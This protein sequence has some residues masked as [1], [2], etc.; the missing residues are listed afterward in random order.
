MKIL[1]LLN[2]PYP[3]G[4]ALTKRF[5]LYAKGFRE[6]GHISKFIIP[7]P[8][9]KFG[10]SNNNSSKGSFEGVPFEYA[11]KKCERSN[12]FF[13]R[14][15]HDIYGSIRTGFMIIKEN[16]DIVITDS[17]SLLFYLYIKTIS[18]LIPYKFVQEKCEV[19][20][21]K[22]DKLSLFAKIHVKIMSRFF[23][24]FIVINTQLEE[25]IIHDLKIKTPL[26][27]IPILVEDFK[28]LNS[29]QIDKTIVY[30]GTFL[31]RKDG[32]LTIISAFSKFRIAH[33][34]YKLLLT[35]IPDNSPDYQKINELI[36]Q[37]N[38][39]NQVMFTGYLKEKELRKIIQNATLLI[40]AKPENRQNH[41]NFPTKIGEYMITG[42]PILATRVGVIG[43]LLTDN[44]NIFFAN[45]EADA[46]AKKMNYI[47]ENSKL[48][49]EVGQNGRLYA[50]QN[51]NYLFHTVKMLD[52][53]AKL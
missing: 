47:I 20:Y 16:P 45:C 19:D 32:I 6:N 12:N 14:R 17:F 50:I 40:I 39:H 10:Q 29:S 52:F 42:R 51:F 2:Q 3:N 21:M 24:G 30:T 25:Y 22:E 4:Y 1:L 23:N 8:T 5:Q 38:V 43:D 9:E 18:I 44:E 7:I 28:S 53:F 34:D 33:Q 37:N 26:I 13:V 36:N 48:G 41:Y 35:G 15:Y 27:K 31:E 49:D 11:W 46:M